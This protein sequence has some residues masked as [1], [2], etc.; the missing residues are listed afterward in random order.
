MFE[1]NTCEIEYSAGWAKKTIEQ[2]RNYTV[3]LAEMPT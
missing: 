2:A 3:W 1:E